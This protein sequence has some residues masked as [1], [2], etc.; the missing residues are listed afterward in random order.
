MGDFLLDQILDSSSLINTRSIP[1][2][3][4]LITSPGVIAELKDTW[5]H[6][7]IISL[8]EAQKITVIRPEGIF[9]TKIQKTL[10]KLGSE[11][12]NVDIEILAL[13][14]Q[15][16]DSIIITDDLEIQNIAEFLS[17]AYQPATSHKITVQLKWFYFCPGCRRRYSIKEVQE[18]IC[19]NCGSTLKKK[20]RP[21]KKR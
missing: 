8:I 15:I 14:L 17:L 16:K 3:T 19:E 12:S 20:A 9:I 11:I 10:R 1:Q 18:K 5:S 7:R 2:G 6:L 21:L 4:T 13:G